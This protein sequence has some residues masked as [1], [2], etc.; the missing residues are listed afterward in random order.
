MTIIM[1]CV[2]VICVQYDELK[3]RERDN[4]KYNQ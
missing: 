3:I 4:N 1:I 2:Y